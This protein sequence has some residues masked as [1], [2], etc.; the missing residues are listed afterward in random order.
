LDKNF[1]ALLCKHNSHI[2]YEVLHSQ[3]DLRCWG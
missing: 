2:A 3:N 1:F